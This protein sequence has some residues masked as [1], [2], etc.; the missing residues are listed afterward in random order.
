MSNRKQIQLYRLQKVL[1][2]CQDC[3]LYRTRTKIVVG[4]G[5][6][7]SKILL[8]GES[9]GK[10]E[11]EQGLPFV[12]KSGQLLNE[13]FRMLEIN[14]NDLYISNVNHCRA[15][16][17]NK[18]RPPTEEEMNACQK[19]TNNILKIVNPEI[20]VA[21][22]NTPLNFFF[23]KSQGITKI[24]GIEKN[25]KNFKVLPVYHPSFVLRNGGINSQKGKEFLEDFK[26]MKDKWKLEENI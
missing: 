12:G 3:N 21:L 22:G 16:T 15:C 19:Y 7:D 18:D 17:N 8:M 6:V 1:E 23:P 4:Q 20:I 13:V 2:N 14:R 25:Y 9:P 11:D 26:K 10:F 24:H 5:N